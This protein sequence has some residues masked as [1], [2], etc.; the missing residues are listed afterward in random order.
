MQAYP[1]HIHVLQAIHH[2]ATFTF[3]YDRR[4]LMI[5]FVRPKDVVYVSRKITF[6]SDARLLKYE[7]TDVTYD[8]SR[9][10]KEFGIQTQL[11]PIRVDDK[12]VLLIEKQ[13]SLQ[14]DWLIEQE[15][16]QTFFSH[17]FAHQIGIVIT[18]KMIDEDD[19]KM[20]FD[21]EVIEPSYDSKLFQKGLDATT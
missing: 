18:K 6:K 14:F 19:S 21:A 15:D 9:G 20:L 8:V 2:K 1:H 7:P 16:L 12:A 4:P 11:S 13:D 5:G 17:P 3:R 10:L